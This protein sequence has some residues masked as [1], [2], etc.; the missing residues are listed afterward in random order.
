MLME[1]VTNYV[2]TGCSSQ[3]FALKCMLNRQCQDNI[4]APWQSSDAGSLH[5]E[6]RSALRMEIGRYE[7]LHLNQRV[8]F[9][10][11]ENVED[12]AHVI[13]VCPLYEDIRNTLFNCARRSCANFDLFTDA[14]KLCF[15]LSSPDIF[16]QS[17]KACH[18][19]LMS[20]RGILY[21]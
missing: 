20:R 3:I 15:L 16:R 21:K 6:W 1:L 19:I 14:D 5:Y 8:C 2:P 12:E 18:D 7:K 13:L 4:E 17:A 9:H 10:C 11:K